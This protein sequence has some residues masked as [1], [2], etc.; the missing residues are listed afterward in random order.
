LLRRPDIRAAEQQLIAAHANIGAARA[1]F[2]PRISLTMGLGQVSNT[3]VHLFG[4]SPRSTSWSFTPDLSVPIFDFGRNNANLDAAK[5]GRLAAVAQYEK[6]IQSAF[7]EVADALAGRATYAD[8]LIAL[9]TQARSERERYRLS[10]LSYRNGAASFLDLLDAQ[11]SLFAVEQALAQVRLAQRVNEVALYKALGGGWSPAD[12][13]AAAQAIA[14]TSSQAGTAASEQVTL[15][16]PTPSSAT[17]VSSSQSGAVVQTPVLADT[18]SP[19]QTAISP[20]QGAGAV[21]AAQSAAGTQAS[22]QSKQENSKPVK[23]RTMDRSKLPTSGKALDKAAQRTQPQ[24]QSSEAQI[25]DRVAA[26]P[27]EDTQASVVVSDAVHA[28]QD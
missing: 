13:Q 2:F 18:L 12:E 16:S 26:A 17:A 7:R 11:R 10:E 5:A 23:I 14:K 15:S 20:A 8:Q 9:E 25:S 27:H 21:A 1:A 28:H 6:T 24:S 4:G 22:Q 3:L 19:A